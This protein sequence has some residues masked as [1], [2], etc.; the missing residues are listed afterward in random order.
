MAV[1][2]GIGFVS[3]TAERICADR[4]GYIGDRAGAGICSA[5]T[6]SGISAKLAVAGMGVYGLRYFLR[7][8][9]KLFLEN[10][11]QRKG[12]LYPFGI[13]GHCDGRAGMVWQLWELCCGLSGAFE[14]SG[15]GDDSVAGSGIYSAW[16]VLYGGLFF[17]L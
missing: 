12:R 14:T 6:V 17:V 9:S 2:A 5:G 1:R 13:W 11:F 15:G 10:V 3:G 16:R 4:N 8:L 7:G